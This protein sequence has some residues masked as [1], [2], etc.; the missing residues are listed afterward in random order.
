[1]S[2]I[3]HRAA[4]LERVSVSDFVIHSAAQAAEAVLASENRV[5]LSD[6]DAARV[7]ELFENPPEP[8]ER[9]KAAAKD[10]LAHRGGAKADLS[11]A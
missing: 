5:W 11:R 9:L 7:L 10:L 4:D 2:E 6:R 3:V 1:V 8:N